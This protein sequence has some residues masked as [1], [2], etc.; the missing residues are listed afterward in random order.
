MEVID[1]NEYLNPYD[2][3]S[4]MT[5]AREKFKEKFAFYNILSLDKGLPIGTQSATSLIKVHVLWREFMDWCACHP[6]ILLDQ[7]RYSKDLNEAKAELEQRIMVWDCYKSNIAVYGPLRH[8]KSGFMAV[9]AWHGKEWFGLPI[10]CYRFRYNDEAFG[11]YVYLNEHKLM[12]AVGSVSEIVEKKGGA[13]LKWVGESKVESDKYKQDIAEKF[14]LK[15]VLAIVEEA[16]KVVGKDHRTLLSFFWED[17]TQEWGHY[18]NGIVYITPDIDL[19]NRDRI[20]PYLDVLIGV[21]RNL[22]IPNT[23][24]VRIKHKQTGDEKPIVHF[25]REDYYPLWAHNAP[26][27]SRSLVT[28]KDIHKIAKEQKEKEKEDGHTST[29]Q[30]AQDTSSTDGTGKVKAR[31]GKD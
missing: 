4:D 25:C 6:K 11:D 12:E 28:S 10:V 7:S 3:P 21:S 22:D 20:Q 5:E 8:G 23:S 2:Y 30:E 14:N 19:L 29:K 24:N 26:I 1:L 13:Y 15:G 9:H 16:N 27:A 31:R 17:F 18:G